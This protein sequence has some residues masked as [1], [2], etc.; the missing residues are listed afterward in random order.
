MRQM[1]AQFFHKIIHTNISQGDL[2]NARH[3]ESQKQPPGVKQSGSLLSQQCPVRF[4]HKYIGATSPK[5]V[6]ANLSRAPVTDPEQPDP[7]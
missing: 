3:D 2:P 6:P 5:G 1:Y 7:D 4:L